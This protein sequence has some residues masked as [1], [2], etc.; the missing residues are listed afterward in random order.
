[1]VASRISRHPRREREPMNVKKSQVVADISGKQAVIHFRATH[2]Q[3]QGVAQRI[4]TEIQEIADTYDV[5]L[6]VIN[7]ARIQHMTSA[8]IGQMISLNKSL[9]D[10]GIKLR[11]CRMAPKVE[12][13][14]R[15]CKL[16]KVIPL[17]RTE[18][19]ALSG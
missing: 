19:K 10:A 2:V 14:Y 18:A 17:Y 4:A 8:F 11:L 3:E 9:K 12:E 7:F 16:Q 1:M 13:A 15:I 5:D 6:L